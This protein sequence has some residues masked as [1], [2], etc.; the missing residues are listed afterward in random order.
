MSISLSSNYFIVVRMSGGDSA[1]AAT[2]PSHIGST[3]TEYTSGELSRTI[4]WFC[5]Y[6]SMPYIVS[7]YC[8][9]VRVVRVVVAMTPTANISRRDYLE[10]RSCLCVCDNPNDYL[11]DCV[12]MISYFGQIGLVSTH[13]ISLFVFC[14]WLQWLTR[15]TSANL[16]C[17]SFNN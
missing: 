16:F 4:L 11:I 6:R 12:V 17:F 13:N 7:Q 14:F 2:T 1:G 5:V 8:R 3:G 10:H 9:A 15:T